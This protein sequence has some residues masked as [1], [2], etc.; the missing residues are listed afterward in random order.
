M[1]DCLNPE[2]GEFYAPDAPE[3]K[4][5]MSMEDILER[6]DPAAMLEVIKC[7]ICKNWVP[8]IVIRTHTE[9]HF[10]NF[11]S[12]HMCDHCGR[13]FRDSNALRL[14]A[15]IHGEKTFQCEFCDKKF[16]TKTSLNTHEAA[17]HTT[18]GHRFCDNC[19]ESFPTGRALESHMKAKHDIENRF[20]CK[21][22]KK[23]YLTEE[24]LKA[25]EAQEACKEFYCEPCD[26]Y[27]TCTS[28]LKKHKKNHN[29]PNNQPGPGNKQ[30]KPYPCNLCYKSYTRM[31]QLKEHIR[32]THEKHDDDSS[33]KSHQFVCHCGKTFSKE[34]N[35]NKHRQAHLVE[36]HQSQSSY[37]DSMFANQPLL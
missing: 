26:R 28:E 30:I 6:M 7:S 31:Y 34:T 9:E 3:E 2:N 18:K 35:Y 12:K 33:A 19:G 32:K 37:Q 23:Y 14:H 22:C 29:A 20:Q 4:V 27:F 24:G 25:H 15:K 8:R 21:L 11:V 10:E 16:Y 13:N 36:L 1:E 17:K 5:I